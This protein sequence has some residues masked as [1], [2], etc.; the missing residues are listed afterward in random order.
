MPTGWEEMLHCFGGGSELEGS[1]Q[2]KF[3]GPIRGN[4]PLGAGTG[5]FSL[6]EFVAFRKEEPRVPEG[7]NDGSLAIHCQGQPQNAT[8][9]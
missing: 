3:R 2:I 5:R 1:K 7:P 8:V 6:S 9:P 4:A